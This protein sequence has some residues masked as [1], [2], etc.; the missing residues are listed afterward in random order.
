MAQIYDID[1]LL[2]KA[3]SIYDGVR[4]IFRVKKSQAE[5]LSIGDFVNQNGGVNRSDPG[6]MEDW[7]PRMKV[8]SND[9]ILE[10]NELIVNKVTNSKQTSSSRNNDASR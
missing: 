6:A 8:S 5:V 2:Y 7:R 3:A 1:I 9:I 10:G 4:K